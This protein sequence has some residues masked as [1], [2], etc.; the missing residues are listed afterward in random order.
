MSL[1]GE[2]VEALVPEEALLMAVA[3]R[4]LGVAQ[5]EVLVANTHNCDVARRLYRHP[6][7]QLLERASTVGYELSLYRVSDVTEFVQDDEA[8]GLFYRAR[9]RGALEAL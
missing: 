2:R 6:D 8:I 3:A 9:D 4:L 5:S 1:E 7:K